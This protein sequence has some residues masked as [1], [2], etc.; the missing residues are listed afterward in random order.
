[1]PTVLNQHRI[2]AWTGIRAIAAVWVVLFHLACFNLKVDFGWLTPIVGRGELG[3]D[4]FFILSGLVI[5]LVHQAEFESWKPD[6]AIRFWVLRFARIYPLH[7]LMLLVMAAFE[8]TESAYSWLFKGHAPMHS[9]NS[10]QDFFLSLF[11]IHDWETT[12][13][14]SFNFP[15]WSVS[16]EWFA[17]LLFPFIT[18][19]LCRVRSVWLNLTLI[20]ISL[21]CLYLTC[22]ISHE[23][24]IGF[25][26]H[27]GLIRI[28]TEFITGCCIYNIL[29]T[30]QKPLP[31]IN[32]IGLAA[33]ILIPVLILQKVHDIWVVTCMALLLYALP[34]LSGWVKGIF[35]N[36]ILVFGGEISYAIYMVHALIL[37]ILNDTFYCFIPHLRWTPWETLGLSLLLLTGVILAATVLNRYI[38]VPARNAIRNYWQN[39]A[40]AQQPINA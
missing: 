35:A 33:L 8:Q 39:R 10:I 14:L 22:V 24:G 1:M 32:L 7:L 17:Y 25:T 23:T 30:Q 13:T 29:K 38:E 34:M 37:H 20:A 11:N 5:S 9:I 3:V 18:L 6:L 2:D 36:R 4:L 16:A 26:Y 21:T 19:F 12:K 15:S 40:M 27:L 31:G 28:G